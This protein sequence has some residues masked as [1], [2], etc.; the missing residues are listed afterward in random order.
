MGITLFGRG[1]KSQTK[2]ERYKS[3]QTAVER[4]KGYLGQQQDTRDGQARDEGIR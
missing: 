4:Q 3:I 1:A 2:K